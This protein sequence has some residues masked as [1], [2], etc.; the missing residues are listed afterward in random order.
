VT[1]GELILPD[2]NGLDIKKKKRTDCV[3]DV[4]RHTVLPSGTR[5]T[6][7][8]VAFMYGQRLNLHALVNKKEIHQMSESE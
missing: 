6:A 8:V 3:F 7:V 1:V 5:K 4:T 2:I